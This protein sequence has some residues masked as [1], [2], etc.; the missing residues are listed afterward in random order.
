MV[1]QSHSYGI[2]Q[3][4]AARHYLLH[5]LVCSLMPR[6]LW[7]VDKKGAGVTSY[8]PAGPQVVCTALPNWADGLRSPTPADWQIDCSHQITSELKQRVRGEEAA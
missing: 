3:D 2:Q 8:G 5:A 4:T 1:G 7:C 6:R